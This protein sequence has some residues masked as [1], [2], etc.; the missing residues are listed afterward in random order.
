MPRR[1][2]LNGLSAA[3]RTTLVNL[4]LQYI[5]DAVV[6]THQTITHSDVHIFTGAPDLHRRYGVISLCQRWRPICAVAEVESRE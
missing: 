1:T 6:A 4:M 2:D 5:N 3:N